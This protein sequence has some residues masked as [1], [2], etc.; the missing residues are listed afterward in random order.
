MIGFKTSSRK[1]P[2]PICGR[3]SDGCSLKG[4]LLWCRRGST[5]N[6][7]DKHPNLKVGDVIDGMAC[8][9]L[10]EDGGWATFR[11][12]RPKAEPEVLQRRKWTYY[13]AERRAFCHHRIDFNIG[14]KKNWWDKGTPV[15]DLLPLY[16]EELPDKGDLLFLVEGETCADALRQLGFTATSVPNGSSTWKGGVPQLPKLA[17]STLILCPDRDAP[18]LGLMERVAAAYPDHKWL[19]CNPGSSQW[20]EPTD[21]Y[22]I[23]DWI[24]D[25]ANAE[26]ILNAIEL[27]KPKVALP[28][29]NMRLGDH[30]TEK[31]ALVKMEESDLAKLVADK[32]AGSLKFNELSQAIEMDSEK[33]EEEDVMLSYIDLQEAG[34]KCQKN[35][36][37]DVFLHA[38]RQDR[39][40]PV[41]DYLDSC[42]DPLPELM[43]QNIAGELLGAHAT[44]FDNSALRKWLIYA[45]ARVY[46][47]GC[48]PGIV[49]ILSGP[50]HT[51]KTRFYNTL[52]SHAWFLEG[53]VKSNKDADD[54]V[55]L[56]MRWICEWGELD[57]G[58]KNHE[59]ASLKNFITRKEDVVRQAYGKNHKERAR[60]FVLCGT[61]NKVDGFFSD[62]TGNRRFVVFP[63]QQQIDSEKIERLRD[64][65]WASAV[66]DYRSGAIWFLTKDEE[67]TNNKRNA[68][69][70]MVDPW[71]DKIESFVNFKRHT[72]AFLASDILTHCIDLPPERQ[73]QSHLFRVNRTLISLG[74]R[75]TRIKMGGRQKKVWKRPV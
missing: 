71:A 35:T 29:W 32:L 73:T 56:H 63:I 12:D 74:F 23:A 28:A 19:R 55:A 65:I 36:W 52:A 58:I 24:D 48:P 64:R 2:C 33:L 67:E 26:K 60:Q 45:V 20:L 14:P 21:G 15:A 40:H 25:G 10:G 17:N 41:R 57:G 7:L 37:I 54:L 75:E 46:D 68:Q 39:Y 53:F 18:G 70:F 47:P 30:R 6:P 72:D 9:S 16:Y 34:I 3:T 62:E 5:S 27:E 38:A 11:E 49:H 31:G 8:V 66:C 22:D 44:E 1:T 69:M 51:H 59:T 61:T 13:D 4:E 50:Q 42:T 43:W